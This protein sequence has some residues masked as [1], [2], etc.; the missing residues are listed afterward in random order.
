[1]S[2]SLKRR[3]VVAASLWVL[4]LTVAGGVALDLAFRASVTRAFDVNLAD[5]LRTLI[6]GVEAAG[7]RTWWL[8]QRP[9]DPRYESIYAG[10]YWQIVDPLGHVERSRSLW[11]ASLPLAPGDQPGAPRFVSIEGPAGQALR[12]VEQS[13]ALP[14][15]DRP[16]SFQL[17]F[18]RDALDAEIARFTRLLAIALSLL[19]A[20]LLIAIWLQVGYGLQPLRRMTRALRDVREGRRDSLDPDQ[21]AEVQPL[22]DELDAVLAHNRRLVERARSSSADLAHALKTPLSVMV[23]ELHAP[24][25]DWRAVMSRE[26]GRTRELVNR[27][28]NRAA[29]TGTGRGRRTAITPVVADILSAMRRI[30][31]D[32]GIAFDASIDASTAFAGERED[33]EEMLGNLIDNAGKWASAHVQVAATVHENVVRIEVVDDGPG[34]S[35]DECAD[36]RERGRRFDEMTPGSGLG[37]AIVGDIADSYDGR[38]HLGR[39]ALGGL[40]ATLELPAAL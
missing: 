1:M 18:S 24:G 37:L 29:T 33:L 26:L 28:L 39:A 2:G 10:R 21:P 35:P 7:D 8:S 20:G 31:A 32:R 3:L 30:H 25:D 22:V 13:I 27:H 19:A 23:A 9:D 5:E 15:L 40:S 34:M 36:A 14:R 11:D 4:T 12:A 6:A 17:S 38:L 16:L